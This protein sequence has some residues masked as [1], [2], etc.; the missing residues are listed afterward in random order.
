MKK[1]KKYNFMLFTIIMICIILF[2]LYFSTFYNILE[3]A[4]ESTLDPSE[5]KIEFT[6]DFNNKITNLGNDFI[7][8]KNIIDS[9]DNILPEFKNYSSIISDILINDIN[10]LAPIAPQIDVLLNKLGEIVNHPDVKNNFDIFLKNLKTKINEN[11]RVPNKE[12]LFQIT[13]DDIFQLINNN[14][15]Q[16]PNLVNQ[17]NLNNELN[18]VVSTNDIENIIEDKLI[19][20]GG[21]RN[22]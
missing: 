18:T 17:T 2:N 7:A 11:L 15:D 16:M 22:Y 3:Y 13:Q 9:S 21:S 5:N 19:A 4:D 1:I 12:I 14:S 8:I 10:T 6:S 20:L